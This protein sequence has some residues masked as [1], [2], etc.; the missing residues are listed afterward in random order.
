[1]GKA[2]EPHDHAAAAGPPGASAPGEPGYDGEVTLGDDA[3]AGPLDQY[4]SPFGRPD[5]LPENPE[6]VPP[7][8]RAKVEVVDRL[9]EEGGGGD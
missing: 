1:M 4:E 7:D 5:E 8:I 9:V 2:A 3:V 6:D